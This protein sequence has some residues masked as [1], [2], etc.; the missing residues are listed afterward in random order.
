MTSVTYINMNVIKSSDV[1]YKG[2]CFLEYSWVF[3]NW[4]WFFYADYW[5]G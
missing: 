4:S 5:I 1:E 2:I 3:S